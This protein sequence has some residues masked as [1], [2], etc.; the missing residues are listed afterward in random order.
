MSM[1]PL[2]DRVLVKRLESFDV[3]CCMRERMALR[4]EWSND[5]SKLARLDATATAGR[6]DPSQ[7][8]ELTLL[9]LRLPGRGRASDAS[10]RRIQ[11][12]R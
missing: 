11:R 9:G 1:R 2:H 7:L 8:D 3:V 5:L 10:K 6:L 4:A 12:R